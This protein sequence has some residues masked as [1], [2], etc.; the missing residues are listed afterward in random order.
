M[1]VPASLRLLGLALLGILVAGAVAIAASRLASQQIGLASQPISAGDALAPA[2]RGKQKPRHAE[3]HR[4]HRQTTT[5]PEPTTVPSAPPIS[6]EPTYS[7]PPSTNPSSP[8]YE[9][10]PSQPS[11]QSHDGE[12]SG[13]GGGGGADD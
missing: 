5:S 3:P 12:H 7:P 10:E 4:G 11:S 13:A 2:P 9:Y 8:P 1:K 6:P